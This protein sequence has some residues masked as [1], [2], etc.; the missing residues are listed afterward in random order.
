M[1]CQSFR[2]KRWRG[3]GFQKDFSVTFY[4]DLYWMDLIFENLYKAL[5]R[6]GLHF[7]FG[8]LFCS[9][10]IS[11]KIFGKLVGSDSHRTVPPL[12][13]DF[14]ITYILVIFNWHFIKSSQIFFVYL[15]EIST[16]LQKRIYNIGVLWYTENV[17]ACWK[18]GPFCF[19]KNRRAA[20]TGQKNKRRLR[21]KRTL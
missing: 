6:R 8:F 13:C 20:I 18:T 14:I 2:Y 1:S 15:G 5:H 21:R 4:S 10:Q 19:P 11:E 16:I 9:I 7:W 12:F 17:G 3:E